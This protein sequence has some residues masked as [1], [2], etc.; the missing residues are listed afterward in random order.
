MKWIKP[1]L[2]LFSTLAINTPAAASEVN[3][4]PKLKNSSICQSGQYFGETV[5]GIPH[6][7]G[8]CKEF[9]INIWDHKPSKYQK[10]YYVGEFLNGEPNGVGCFVYGL[11]ESGYS[12]FSD[13]KCADFAPTLNDRLTFGLNIYFKGKAFGKESW[14]YESLKGKVTLNNGNYK[15]RLSKNLV[16]YNMHTCTPRVQCQGDVSFDLLESVL[17]KEKRPSTALR[18][19]KYTNEYCKVI[20]RKLL[21]GIEIALDFKRHVEILDSPKDISISG[22]RGFNFSNSTLR[23]PQGNL[24][25][26]TAVNFSSD[27]LEAI[28]LVNLNLEKGSQFNFDINEAANLYD[29]FT[30]P[31]RMLSSAEKSGRF[32]QFGMTDLPIGEQVRKITERGRSAGWCIK[33]MQNCD[34]IMKNWY[35]Q[36]L[37]ANAISGMKDANASEKNNLISAG[38]LISAMYKADGRN[39]GHILY[40]Q[41]SQMVEAAIKDYRSE[42]EHVSYRQSTEF[43]LSLTKP[44]RA[45]YG[46]GGLA[47]LGG[48]G[49]VAIKAMCEVSDCSSYDG[50]S[51]AYSGGSTSAKSSNGSSNLTGKPS[52]NTKGKYTWLERNIKYSHDQKVVARGKCAN[53]RKFDVRY[54]P[55]NGN[56]FKYYIVST[57]GSS[58][59]NVAARYCT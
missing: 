35:H 15:K 48:T 56:S 52:I 13:F 30:A 47:I 25:F 41:T 27:S 4:I 14:D 22:F 24:D 40:P 11:F 51:G 34:V 49:Y 23:A 9:R 21:R 10:G 59:D 29:D 8:V 33:D 1:T 6:G 12:Q 28:E 36:M 32:L 18:C 3:Y 38:L 16:R 50:Q 43:Y 17:E 39:R 42:L 5:D 44:Q 19:D 31:D 37:A 7:V 53:G 26:N 55:N 58:E 46:I 2:A 54:Y 45:A 57:S 20:E